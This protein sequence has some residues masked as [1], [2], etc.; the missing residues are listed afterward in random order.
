MAAII[1]Q[2]RYVHNPLPEGN[3]AYAL[4]GTERLNNTCAKFLFADCFSQFTPVVLNL[5]VQH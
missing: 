3:A 5:R 2:K 1:E 4:L